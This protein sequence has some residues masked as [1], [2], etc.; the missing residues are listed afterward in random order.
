METPLLDRYVEAFNAR[1]LD[2]LMELF[3]PEAWATIFQVYGKTAIR[4]HLG[5]LLQRLSSEVRL[6]KGSMGQQGV[7]FTEYP[8]RLG[9]TARGGYYSFEVRDGLISTLSWDED[10]ARASLIRPE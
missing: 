8:G 9:G 7:A 2:A 3:H 4:K 6:R 1:D 10:V 5:E